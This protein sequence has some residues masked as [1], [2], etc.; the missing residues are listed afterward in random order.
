MELTKTKAIITSVII[1][2]A[3]LPKAGYIAS[4]YYM[5]GYNRVSE[6]INQTTERALATIG[7]TKIK[8]LSIQEE[9]TLQLAINQEAQRYKLNPKF[10]SALIKHESAED[11][12]ALSLKGAIGYA[13]IMPDNYKRCG[14][15]KKSELWDM[16]KNVRCGAQIIAEELN[17]YKGDVLMALSSYNG[18]PKCVNEVKGAEPKCAESRKHASEVLRLFA[19]NSM[20]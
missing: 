14:L 6:T 3:V 13:Q 20:S 15:K 19:E 1:S 7:L 12:D 10:L 2:A 17:T 18:G 16:E 11:S 5:R 8:P 9:K 4:D